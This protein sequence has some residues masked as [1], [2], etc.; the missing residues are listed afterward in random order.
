MYS[1]GDIVDLP[2]AYIKKLLD[3]NDV[4]DNEVLLSYLDLLSKADL[5]DWKSTILLNNEVFR[6][7]ITKTDQ[8]L[9]GG[10]VLFG[11]EKNQH[12][13]RLRAI[14]HSL[15]TSN[16]IYTRYGNIHRLALDNITLYDP[17]KLYN[18]NIRNMDDAKRT[19]NLLNSYIKE[20]DYNEN[21]ELM[22]IFGNRRQLVDYFHSNV[23]NDR[24]QSTTIYEG[25]DTI[26]RLPYFY[27]KYKLLTVNHKPVIERENKKYEEV[28]NLRDLFEHITLDD[29]NR[30]YNRNDPELMN[31]M[32]EYVTIVELNRQLSK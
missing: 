19:I 2:I 8:Q 12:L 24:F 13:T 32:V 7:L 30:M 25:E 11:K 31:K 4:N 17:E 29:I 1:L 20:E 16:V 22:K 5:L 26:I 14:L 3:R 23:N 21:Y 10:I 15:I 27:D 28:K 9:S 6:N 18:I